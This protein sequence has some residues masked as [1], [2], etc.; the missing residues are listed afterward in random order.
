MCGSP[1]CRYQGQIIG[2]FKHVKGDMLYP[3]LLFNKD[4]FY[5]LEICY[6]RGPS[7]WLPGIHLLNLICQLTA[8]LNYHDVISDYLHG[9]LR[10]VGEM[11][12]SEYQESIYGHRCLLKKSSS[13]LGSQPTD[14]GFKNSFHWGIVS[15]NAEISF[16]V[17][18]RFS[19]FYS[20]DVNRF[21]NVLS[22]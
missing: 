2:T 10:E 12:Q 4:A 21:I 18:I 20:I 19:L 17:R 22:G 9:I 11:T 5:P 14:T 15:S 6:L 16:M 7:G 13:H 1:F 8:I 3:V